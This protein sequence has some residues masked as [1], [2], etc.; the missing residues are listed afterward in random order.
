MGALKSPYFQNGRSRLVTGYS[1]TLLVTAS[2]VVLAGCSTLKNTQN[3]MDQMAYYTGHM[4]SSTARMANA[5][6]RMEAKSDRLLNNL[7]NKGTTVE[8][9]VQNY[10]QAILDNERGM[11]KALQGIREELGQLQAKGPVGPKTEIRE[12]LK[13]DAALQ[14]RLKELESRLAAIESTIEAKNNRKAP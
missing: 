3:T 7:G 8:R 13:A 5:T 6:E 14:A 4:A 10:S 1:K 12:Q 11:I 2:F 9:A